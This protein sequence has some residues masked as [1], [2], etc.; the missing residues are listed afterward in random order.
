MYNKYIFGL[1]AVVG[2]YWLSMSK[3]PD[4]LSFIEVNYKPDD[5]PP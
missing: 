2:I 5:N 4:L 1:I 3:I